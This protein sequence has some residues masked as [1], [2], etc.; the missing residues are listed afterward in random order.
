MVISIH[1]NIEIAPEIPKGFV[2]LN[3]RNQLVVQ[4]KLWKELE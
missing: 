1:S 3:S 4:S 2:T